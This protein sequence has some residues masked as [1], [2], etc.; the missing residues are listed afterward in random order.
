MEQA[1]IMSS[2]RK[3]ILFGSMLL[4]LFAISDAIFTDMGL[5]YNHIEEAN[6][7][8]LFL[9]DKSILSF[10]VVK[11]AL[12]L[13]LMYFIAKIEIK[14]FFIVLFFS[15]LLLYF[16]VFFIHLFWLVTV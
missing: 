6:P 9:Y 4:L 11:I 14:P 2:T 5:R 10:Y 13:L 7:F 8:M 15:T 12:P 1:V 3:I 16:F